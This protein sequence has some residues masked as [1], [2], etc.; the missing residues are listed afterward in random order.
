MAN[1]YF[2]SISVQVIAQNGQELAKPYFVDLLIANILVVNPIPYTQ[3]NGTLINAIEVIYKEDRNIQPS[4]Y[5]LAESLPHFK[6]RIDETANPAIVQFNLLY[7]ID[8]KVLN[9]PVQVLLNQDYMGEKIYRA[10]VNR[11]DIQYN[12]GKAQIRKKVFTVLGD[13]TNAYSA[14]GAYWGHY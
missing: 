2:Q 14:Y 3:T 7:S 10:D 13:S 5:M 1:L 9:S 6:A 12:M 8:H 11:T 4:I